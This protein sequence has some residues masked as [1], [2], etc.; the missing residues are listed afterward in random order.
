MMATS[1]DRARAGTD[2]RH[3]LVRFD[4]QYGYYFSPVVSIRVSEKAL[5][6]I[7]LLREFSRFSRLLMQNACKT[8]HFFCKGSGCLRS[9]NQSSFARQGRVRRILKD[10]DL[11]SS[12]A[13]R[14]PCPSWPSCRWSTGRWTHATRATSGGSKIRVQLCRGRTLCHPCNKESRPARNLDFVRFAGIS[15]RQNFC[16]HRTSSGKMRPGCQTMR[17]D[18]PPMPLQQKHYLLKFPCVGN[19]S[20]PFSFISLSD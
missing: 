13:L 7:P 16:G 10:L 1:Q 11:T 4:E 15:S 12:R 3:Q 9:D 2:T 20:K 18:F 19:F 17:R 5:A 6:N 8:Y 14:R